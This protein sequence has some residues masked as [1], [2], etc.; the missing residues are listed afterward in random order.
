MCWWK[1]SKTTFEQ[2]KIDVI[3]LLAM[4]QN[5]H[6]AIKLE[7]QMTVTSIKKKT[8]TTTTAAT[9]RKESERDS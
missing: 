3:P 9:R 8:A 2:P 6:F 4:A 1:F 5:K 7:R